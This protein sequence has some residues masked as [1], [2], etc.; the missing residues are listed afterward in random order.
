MMVTVESVSEGHPDKI[1]DGIADCLLDAYLAQDPIARVAL[2]VLIKSHHVFIAGE[3]SSTANINIPELVKKRL[4]TVYGEHDDYPQRCH[5]V[6]HVTHQSPDIARGVD[7]LGGAGDQG[8]VYGYASNETPAFMP[9]PVL[10]ANDIMRARYAL[11]QH[12][13]W[14]L[15]DAKVQL[16]FQ[17]HHGQPSALLAVVFSTQHTADTSLNTVTEMFHEHLLPIIPKHFLSKKTCYWI[18]PAGPFVT[19]GPFA[20]C[21]VTG[22]KLM[23]DTYGGIAKHG[24][25]ALSG[26]DPT[27]IDR[28]GAYM[29]RWIAKQLVH[30]QLVTQCTVSLAYAIGVSEP[31]AVYVDA[32][33]TGPYTNT[34][35]THRVQAGVDMTPQGIIKRFDLQRP[36]Y[37]PTATYGHFCQKE[38]PWEITHDNIL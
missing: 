35:L 7:T 33:N 27:K 37:E 21:G 2:E 16:T 30:Q 31:I 28:S 34:I 19:G 11:R 5:V 29:A 32:M 12:M 17:Y 3:V 14:L 36:L 26:K 10:L 25:G 38:Y 8:I 9:M 6:T 23:V 15:P 1:A 4:C 22:R 18:N 20:D 24:G 13:S